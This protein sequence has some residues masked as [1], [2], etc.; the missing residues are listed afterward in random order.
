MNIDSVEYTVQAGDA[1]LFP[2]H[3][4]HFGPRLSPGAVSYHWLHFTAPALEECVLSDDTDI[5]SLPEENALLKIHFPLL[6]PN[7]VQVI[8]HQIY[9][10]NDI[11]E[12]VSALKQT[13]FKVLLY[14]LSRQVHLQYAKKFDRHF[15]E[16][17]NYIRDHFTD[18]FK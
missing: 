7:A 4:T 5:V 2:A 9:D 8:L 17:F 14:E 15:L 1:F 18:A 3:R 12:H 13:L 6:D 16:I 11:E 10:C